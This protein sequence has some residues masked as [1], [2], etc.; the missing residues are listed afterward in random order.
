MGILAISGGLPPLGMPN[1]IPSR[2]F[3]GAQAAKGA[4]PPSG[5]PQPERAAVNLPDLAYSARETRQRLSASLSATTLAGDAAGNAEF[6]SLQLEFDFFRETRAEELA[7]FRRRTDAAGDRLEAGQRADFFAAREEIS[8]RFSFSIGLSGAALNGFAGAAEGAVDAREIIERLLEIARGLLEKADELFEKFFAPLDGG[9][10]AYA[11]RSLDALFS[12]F[13]SEIQAIFSG[14]RGLPFAGARQLE[15]RFEFSASVT[16]TQATVQQGDPIVLDLD[17]DGIELTTYQQG[18]R[19]DLIGS[20]R[21]QQV[22]FVHGGDAFLALDRNGDGVINSG[23]ELFGEQHGAR[24]GFEELRRFDDNGDGVIDRRDAVFDSL[25][26]FRDNGNGVTEP[27]ELLSLA[28]AGIVSI[29]LD[30]AE[31]DKRAAGGNRITQIASF[32]RADGSRGV[33]ADALLNYIV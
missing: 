1:T 22:A 26:L 12:A 9:D 2:L 11:A 18:A 17:G 7:Y 28:E 13:A 16:V 29:S 15:F 3:A 30:Y 19:F 33:A 23:L 20:G 8:A 6:T 25:L 27:G 24:N 4:P 21:A 14:E 10:P 31:V 32:A 5:R